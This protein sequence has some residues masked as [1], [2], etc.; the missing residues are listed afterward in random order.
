VI[1][2]VVETPPA[3][4]ADAAPEPTTRKRKTEDP[5]KPDTPSDEKKD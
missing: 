3:P 4:A 1:E 5:A 2:P